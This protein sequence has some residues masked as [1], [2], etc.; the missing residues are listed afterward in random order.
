MIN[1]EREGDSRVSI[2]AERDLN[3]REFDSIN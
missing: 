1:T 3:E 2:Q